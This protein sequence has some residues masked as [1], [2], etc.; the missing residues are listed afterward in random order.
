MLYPLSIYNSVRFVGKAGRNK[1]LFETASLSLF[2]LQ[3]N[4]LCGQIY[5]VLSN[6]QFS[7]IKFLAPTLIE[8]IGYFFKK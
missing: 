1:S 6:K 3:L 7:D 5:W 2:P 4:F 8:I